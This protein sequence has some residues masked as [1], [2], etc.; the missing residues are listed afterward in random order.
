VRRD[1]GPVHDPLK[2]RSRQLIETFLAVARIGDERLAHA[3]SPETIQMVRNT[4]DRFLSAPLGSKEVAYVVGHLG[5]M[6]GTAHGG[7]RMAWEVPLPTFHWLSEQ[8]AGE[9]LRCS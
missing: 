7:Q 6:L 1:V 5:Q 4:G 2:C 8:F 3:A 9:D